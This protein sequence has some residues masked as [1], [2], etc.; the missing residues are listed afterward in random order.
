METTILTERGTLTLPANIRKALGI[1]G[2]QQMIVETT[3]AGEILLRPASVVPIEI[4]S[5]A[6]I[7]E[8]EQ[9]DK[10]L[11]A[12]LEEHGVKSSG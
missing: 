3:D 11:G 10:A 6:R 9:D 7:A 12:L 8:F 4:Y 1:R 5:E 2:K